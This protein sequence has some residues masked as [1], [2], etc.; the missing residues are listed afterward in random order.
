MI[1]VSNLYVKLQAST[2]GFVRVLH[3]ISF[4]SEEGSFTTFLGPSGCGKST[5]LRAVAGLTLPTDGVINILQSQGAGIPKIGMN[6]QRPV[7]LPWLTVLENA[8]LSFRVSG[9]KLNASDNERV[10]SLLEIVGLSPFKHALPHELSGGMQMRAAL[11]RA[12]ADKPDLLLMDEPFSA[13]DEVSRARIGLELRELAKD[14]GT[15]VLFV[16]HS[17]HEAILLSDSIHVLSAR[18][19]RIVAS[20]ET[21]N[22][23]QNRNAAT[24][25][26]SDYAD[27]FRCIRNTIANVL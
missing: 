19:A 4:S 25:E 13:L 15:T 6:F 7:L 8:V 20:F 24:V 14:Q 1:S 10:S 27:H 11:V 16:T 3:D 23:G 2:G 12:L 5:I 26:S 18:P 21:S 22:L 17:V 9:E